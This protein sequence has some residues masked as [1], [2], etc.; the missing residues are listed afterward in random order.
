MKFAALVALV[1]AKELTENV[2][3][4]YSWEAIAEYERQIEAMGRLVEKNE[5][6]WEKEDE[7]IYGDFF[8]MWE[9]EGP[10]YVPEMMGWLNSKPVQAKHKWERE[11]LM[12]TD[13]G[14][15]F[16]EDIKELMKDGMKMRWSKSIDNNGYT[17]Y[18]NNEDLAE[19]LED[20]IDIKESFIA[21]I[22]NKKL[23]AQASKLDL[24]ALQDPHFKKMWKMF[25]DDMEIDG[26]D[27]LCKK[28]Q[29]HGKFLAKRFANDKAAQKLLGMAKK[30][31]IT[32]MKTREISDMPSKKE[33]GQWMKE[34]DIKPWI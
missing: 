7:E 20:L 9:E 30:L 24:A 34:N 3:A 31:F 29:A 28:L 27:G 8:E 4:H 26:L 32:I 6:R 15:E 19:I 25:Q 5:A 16:M 11:V 10:K 13:E 21:I 33:I 23:M 17:E 12:K 1:G 22:H 14:Q 2:K 18:A